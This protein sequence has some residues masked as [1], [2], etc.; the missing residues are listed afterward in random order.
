MEENEYIDCYSE[1][2]QSII[3]KYISSAKYGKFAPLVSEIFQRFAYY[4]EYS[5]SEMENK[6]VNFT[7]N[8]RAIKFVSENALKRSTNN[9]TLGGFSVPNK[10]IVLNL[11][12]IK[13]KR[14]FLSKIGK[15]KEDIDR[16]I[17]TEI[18]NILTHEVYHAISKKGKYLGVQEHGVS[19]MKKNGV[20][21]N[22]VITEVAS[23]T[24]SLSMNEKSFINNIKQTYGYDKITFFTRMLSDVIGVSEK[25]ILKAGI[26]GRE[27]FQ[28]LIY[29]QFPESNHD[30]VKNMMN[31]TTNIM[32]A[33]LY[34]IEHGVDISGSKVDV[35]KAD[36]YTALTQTMVDLGYLQMSNLPNTVQARK[37]KIYRLNALATI[38]GNLQLENKTILDELDN[39]IFEAVR[40]DV[41]N[42]RDEEMELDNPDIPNEYEEMI[43][44]QDFL[45]FRKW[46]YLSV[47][48]QVL[49]AIQESERNK[50]RYHVG[51]IIFG[52]KRVF[53]DTKTK[54]IDRVG[55]AFENLT[56]R[57][58]EMKKTNPP[59]ITDGRNKENLSSNESF[60]D[61][62]R[63]TIINNNGLNNTKDLNHNGDEKSC[64]SQLGVDDR[65]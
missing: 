59:Q 9:V 61:K 25:A 7:N 50:I 45:D 56:M 47:Q 30:D 5:D 18:Y 54:I 63:V 65:L 41:I 55:D 40:K 49:D 58:S 17:A 26:E 27:E 42:S 44:Q 12:T 29:S 23:T 31:A 28:N 11:D 51:S 14:K 8:V 33:M 43:K 32:L 38:I 13:E 60:D 4:F 20:A 22:E 16:I 35:L 3:D 15:N 62:Y 53:E 64:D 21:L 24:T 19:D 39:S 6:I 10:T 52:T 1:S 48:E 2:L 57:F 46:N 37:Q 36:A 34:S